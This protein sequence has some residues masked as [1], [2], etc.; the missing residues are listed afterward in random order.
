MNL[1]F[2][3]LP[4][5]EGFF[6]FPYKVIL[7]SQ[8]FWRH[9]GALHPRDPST[10]SNP[11]RSLDAVVGFPI[12]LAWLILQEFHSDVFTNMLND[13]ILYLSQEQKLPLLV[14]RSQEPSEAPLC[15]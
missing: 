14:S 2:N 5:E 4:I 10:W 12:V 13:L 15:R 9:P 1:Y 11:H 8:S 6:H 3:Q 7:F